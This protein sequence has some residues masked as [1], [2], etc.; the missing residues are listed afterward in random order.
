MRYGTE[1]VMGIRK[2]LEEAIVTFV[3][4]QYY[5]GFVHVICIIFCKTVFH[6]NIMNYVYHSFVTFSTLFFYIQYIYVT[7]L[8]LQKGRS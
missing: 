1:L 5:S 4:V 7:L 8:Q 2:M 3:K 6:N